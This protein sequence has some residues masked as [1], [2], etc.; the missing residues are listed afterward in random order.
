MIRSQLSLRA[1][2]GKRADLL[3]E[4][5]R[6]EVFV[7]IREQPGFLAAAVLVPEDDADG[8]I[9]EGSW[10]SAEHFERWC[11]SAIRDRLLSGLRHLLA[12]EPHVTVYHAVDTIS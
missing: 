2:P 5:D 9:V 12:E 4:L 7:A 10:S 3:A 1:V 8:A 11:S 6:I